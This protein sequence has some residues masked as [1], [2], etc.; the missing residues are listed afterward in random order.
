M[1]SSNHIARAPTEMEAC[2]CI[3]SHYQRFKN[4][5]Q[6]VAQCKG[7]F[8]SLPYLN[9]IGVYVQRFSGSDNFVLV[10]LLIE[11]EKIFNSS[12]MLGQDF[13]TAVATTD[14][15]SAETTFPLVRTML[16]AVALSSPKQADGISRLLSKQDVEK[17]KSNVDQA[18]L[19][20]KMAMLVFS[21]VGE[22]QALLDN[23]KL[24]GRFLVR[25]A[26]W[27]TKKEG[28]GREKTVFGSLEEIHKAFLSEQ[29]KAAA[30]SSTGDAAGP[31]VA[32]S[33][34]LAL[35]EFCMFLF[36]KMLYKKVIAPTT[37][38]KKRRES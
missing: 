24:V 1:N 35:E 26:L 10:K 5:D 8:S 18:V 36:L 38:R 19:A 21:Q 32:D 6:A 29:T 7:T 22:G 16:L 17:L 3:A 23:V 37:P 13:F 28:K 20:E 30:S 34:V 2:L 9:E 33:K 27:L 14:L 25:G 4:M 31:A 15:G 11:L 12:M